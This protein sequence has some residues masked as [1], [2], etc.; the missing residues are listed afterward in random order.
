VRPRH[1]LGLFTFASECFDAL[2]DTRGVSGPDKKMQAAKRKAPMFA[3]VVIVWLKFCAFGGCD[4]VV[5][6]LPLLLPLLLP[7]IS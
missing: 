5:S 3:A 7:P 4:C 6:F 2:S 1:L